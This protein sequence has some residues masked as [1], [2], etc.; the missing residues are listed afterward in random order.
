MRNL[1]NVRKGR[2]LW[3]R[4]HISSMHSLHTGSDFIIKSEMEDLSVKYLETEQYNYV[5]CRLKQTTASRNKLIRDFSGPMQESLKRRALD[6]LQK[7][8]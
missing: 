6:S 3:L 5:D 1:D 2:N 4:R 7:P 8:H